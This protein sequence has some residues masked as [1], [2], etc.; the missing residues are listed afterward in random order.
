MF[1]LCR[2]CNRPYFLQVCVKVGLWGE[3]VLLRGW[4]SILY[5]EIAIIRVVNAVITLG[6]FAPGDSL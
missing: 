5:S 1:D 4:L 6:R 3:S 2:Y